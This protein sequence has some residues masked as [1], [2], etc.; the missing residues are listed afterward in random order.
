MEANELEGVLQAPL[1]ARP[2]LEL[3]GG[4]KW[5]PSWGSVDDGVA[6]HVC[7]GEAI[8][9]SITRRLTAAMEVGLRVCVALPLG[10]VG[11][12]TESQQALLR[13]DVAIV[14][15]SSIGEPLTLYSHLAEAVWKQ[16]ILIDPPASGS[17]AADFLRSAT[18]V[19][20]P[21]GKRLERAVA[22][23]ASQVPGWEVDDVNYHTDNEELDVLVANNSAKSPWNGTAWI[24][25][26]SKNWAHNVDRPEYDSFHMKVKER[27]GFCRLGMFVA[28]RGF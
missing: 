25:I 15:P 24:L 18:A 14:A 19:P 12:D 3:A 7:Q 28:S 22:F 9:T 21:T 6:V 1:V 4:L 11:L 16:R 2:L 17:T 10:P 13:A 26:E 23:L 5:R 27:G 20:D 8:G